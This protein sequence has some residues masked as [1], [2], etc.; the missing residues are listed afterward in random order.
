[1]N[2]PALLLTGAVNVNGASPV[3]FVGTEK[4]DSNAE[5]PRSLNTMSLPNRVAT[6]AT[7]VIGRLASNPLLASRYNVDWSFERRLPRTRVCVMGTPA[8]ALDSM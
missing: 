1:M 2:A 4:L 6:T 5:G 7:T 3:A 8:R